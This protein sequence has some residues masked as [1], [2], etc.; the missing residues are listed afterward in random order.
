MTAR[1]QKR[2]QRG[3]A[4]IEMALIAP[5]LMMLLFSMVDVGRYTDRQL[6]VQTADRQGARYAAQHPTAWQKAPA[7]AN[8]IE[9]VILAEGGSAG[10][11]NDD[12]HI[13][14]SYQDTSC[15]GCSLLAGVPVTCGS[16]HS[17]SGASGAFVPTGAYTQGTCVK[18]GSLIVLT[19][20]YAY[21]VLT[22]PLS[23]FFPNG[24]TIAAVYTVVETS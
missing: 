15:G 1:H 23:A 12:A 2:F 6:S 10:I 14:I 18:P 24:A 3:Q 8:T 21:T 5:M 4:I 22:P 17:A 19:V 9:G 11:L 7:K 20:N 16:W 13:T